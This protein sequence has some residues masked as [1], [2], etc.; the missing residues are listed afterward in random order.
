MQKGAK[1]DY[2]SAPAANT[3]EQ[4][5]HTIK[6]HHLLKTS[7]TDSFSEDNSMNDATVAVPVKYLIYSQEQAFRHMT[8][9]RSEQEQALY[10]IVDEVLFYFW[11]ALSLSI[12]QDHRDVYYPYLPH[13]FD[14]LLTTERGHEIADYLTFIEETRM[15]AIKGDNLSRK[16]AW[17]LVEVV[18]DYK[19][20]LLA[21]T[22]N[23]S[24]GSA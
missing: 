21:S 24:P 9:Y 20:K 2:T 13:V 4:V 23:S 10:M 18:L 7:M 6:H 1:Y 12:D 3:G 14:L 15:G 19:Q 11:D 22:P 8:K 5:Q 16:R 17:R